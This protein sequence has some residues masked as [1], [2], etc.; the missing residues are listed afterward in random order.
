ME[1]VWNKTP[2]CFLEV[3]QLISKVSV[4]SVKMT[5]LKAFFDQLG[6]SYDIKQLE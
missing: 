4:K 2:E 6:V 3:W 1:V 5:N